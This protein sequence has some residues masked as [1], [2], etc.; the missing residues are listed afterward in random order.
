M[1]NLIDSSAWIEYFD[2]GKNAD[3]FSKP[4]EDL[5]NL[6]VSAIN[7]Y[8]VYKKVLVEKDE[9][10]ALRAV[11]VLQQG[12]VIAI[13]EI[14]ATNAAKLS[15]ELKL[16]MADSII[17]ATARQENAMLWTQDSDFKNIPGVKYF[18]K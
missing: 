9:D 4:I 1:K 10:S 11:G 16:P 6:I 17:L 13:D 12:Q 14:I 2:D 3:Y 15:Y 7:I 18:K 5:S 8:E